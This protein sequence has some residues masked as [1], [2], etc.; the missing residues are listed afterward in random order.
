MLSYKMF[1]FFSLSAVFVVS[2]QPQTPLTNVHLV[3]LLS[4]QNERAEIGPPLGRKTIT[5]P[6]S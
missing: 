4:I 3:Q 2:D 5:V 1:L 6:F